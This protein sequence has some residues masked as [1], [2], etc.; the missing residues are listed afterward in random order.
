M[1]VSIPDAARIELAARYR[2]RHE[3]E[4]ALASYLRGLVDALSLYPASLEG[5]DDVTGELLLADDEAV[6]DDD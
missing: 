6:R 2:V 1:R 5:F 3:A 4:I